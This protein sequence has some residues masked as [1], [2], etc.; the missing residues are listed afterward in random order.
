MFFNKFK[1]GQL[2]LHNNLKVGFL[3]NLK[4]APSY[5]EIIKSEIPMLS[6]NLIIPLTNPEMQWSHIC[7]KINNF[8][9][10]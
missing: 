8:R 1:S 7:N 5:I 3:K 9:L 6:H 2:F 4:N 10:P